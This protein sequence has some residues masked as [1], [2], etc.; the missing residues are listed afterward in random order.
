MK[1]TLRPH[2]VLMIEGRF[3][4]LLIILW[5]LF[6]LFAGFVLQK[7]NEFQST[8]FVLYYLF[9]LA[10]N[11]V[12]CSFLLSYFWQ[13]FWGKLILTEDGIVWR[14]L[15]CKPIQILYSEMKYVERVEF[16]EGNVLYWKKRRNLDYM[17]L[18]ISSCPLPKKRIDKIRSE[19]NLIKFLFTPEVAIALS[20]TV[21]EP[22][23]KKFKRLMLM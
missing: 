2:R 1:K 9:F 19:N 20:E 11:A 4:S 3:F 21:P 15:F 10:V 17:Y 8:K 23:K 12:L 16:R 18:L 6:L 5:F 7:N 22:W 13:L 14:C